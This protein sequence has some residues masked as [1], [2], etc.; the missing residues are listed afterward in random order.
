MSE[1]F[2]ELFSEEIPARLQINA[3]NE[4]KTKIKNFLI[5]NQIQFNENFNVYSTPNRLVLHV[6]KI[7]NEIK[8]SSEEIRGPNVNAPEKALEG[9]I[10][11]NNAIL[12]KIF[13]KNT[14]KGEFYF[15]KKESR[16]IKVSDLLEKNLSEILAKIAWNKSMKWA[17]YDLYWGRPLKSILAIFNKKPLNFVFN[18]IISSN[19]TFIDKSLEEDMKIFKDF[20]SYLKFFRQKG[21]LIDQDLRKKIIQNKINEIINKKNL[22]IEQNDRLIDEIVNIVEKPAVIV[23]DFDKKFLNVPSEILITTMQTL[24]LIHI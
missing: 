22:K 14:E 9:F 18:H 19:K 10:R 23:C 4:L 6:D 13:K 5:E 21:I 17:N 1:L 12:E 24:S 11:S 20:N 15:F 7:P 8:L 3:R 2:V 16:K